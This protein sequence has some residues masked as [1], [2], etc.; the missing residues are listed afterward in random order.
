MQYSVK[1]QKYANK[2]ANNIGEN[3]SSGSK[4]HFL[5]AYVNFFGFALELY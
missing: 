5:I 1:N 4:L 3:E 2:Y